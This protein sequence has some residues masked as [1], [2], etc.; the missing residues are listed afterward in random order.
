MNKILNKL[1]VLI[2]VVYC[3]ALV[4]LGYGIKCM[5]DTTELKNQSA[6]MYTAEIPVDMHIP[7]KQDTGGK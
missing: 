5:R 3:F 4:C 6:Q 1:Y 2:F 7:G